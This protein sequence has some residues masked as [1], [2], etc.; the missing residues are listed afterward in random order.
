MLIPNEHWS[1]DEQETPWSQDKPLS[2][3]SNQGQTSP[4]H[5]LKCCHPLPHTAWPQ[6]LIPLYN[7]T[8]LICHFCLR[9][10]PAQ[11]F[12]HGSM[13]PF[14]HQ[15]SLSPAAQNQSSA[16]KALVK[17]AFKALDPWLGTSS[18]CNGNQPSITPTAQIQHS[19]PL[20]SNQPS[21][22][23]VSPNQE[24]QQHQPGFPRAQPQPKN[25][26]QHLLRSFC[27]AA[28]MQQH[29]RKVLWAT[30]PLRHHPHP[31]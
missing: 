29:M 10:P 28:P 14:F 21:P 7:I 2:S 30:E 31:T 16:V 1:K 26:Q 12:C 3:F 23:L 15:N 20:N 27:P 25:K 22:C 24:Q 18:P 9:T 11:Q 8:S 17:Q 13:S 6:P 19:A 4:Y 5:Y